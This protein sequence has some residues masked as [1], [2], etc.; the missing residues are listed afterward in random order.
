MGKDIYITQADYQS[1]RTLINSGKYNTALDG[2]YLGA[3]ETELRRAIVVKE[4]EIPADIVTMNSVVCVENL[5]TGAQSTY[6]LVFPDRADSEKGKI[7][8]LAPIGT[9]L[10]GERNGNVIEWQVPSGNVRLK[11]VKIEY[12]PEAAKDYNQTFNISD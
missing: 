1:L 5:A 12:Q 6:Q 9:A 3:L 11:I 7:S 2:K 10:I 4:T 8:I